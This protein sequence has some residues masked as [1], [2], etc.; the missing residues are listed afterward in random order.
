LRW[1]TIL[2]IGGVLLATL[3]IVFYALPYRAATGEAAQQLLS[4][5]LLLSLGCGFVLIACGLVARWGIVRG[6]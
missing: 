2:M 6:L 4:G 1:P 5:E 3:M